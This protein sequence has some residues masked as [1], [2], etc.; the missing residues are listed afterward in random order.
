VSAAS[1]WSTEPGAHRAP[2]PAP[3]A[4]ELYRAAERALGEGDR[5]GAERALA[6]LIALG[7]PLLDQALYERARLAYQARAWRAARGHLAALAAIAGTPLAEPGRYLDCRIA[8]E[9]RATDAERCF[10]AYRAAYPRSPHDLDVLA[11]LAQLAHARGGCAATAP[12]RDEL[13]ARYP[14]TDHAAAWRSR[15]PEAP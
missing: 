13:L 3:T 5:A 15:C 2:A 10:V 6:R 14:R 1:P 8:V 11:V 7:G 9:S 4:D 12:L